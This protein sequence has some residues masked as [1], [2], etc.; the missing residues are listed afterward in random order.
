M[1]RAMA[2]AGS[3]IFLVIAPGGLA[4]V[5]PWWISHWAVQAPILGFAVFRLAGFLL[6]LAGIPVLLESFWRFAMEGRGT[7][8]PVLPPEHLVVRGY[9]RYVRNPMY[10]AVVSLILGQ[11]LFFG[12]ERLVAYGCVVWLAMHM[13]VVLY[14]E[15]K[16]RRTF[17]EEYEAFCVQVPRWVPRLSALR[18]AW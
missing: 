13:F 8:A 15:P 4:V 11:G 2:V 14:E 7:P 18:E 3:A 12:S 6:I 17:G 10:V 1:Q 16:L 9:Y 5:A